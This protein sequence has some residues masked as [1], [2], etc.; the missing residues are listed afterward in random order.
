MAILLDR[1]EDVS[2]HRGGGTLAKC[3][4]ASC[5]NRA[6]AGFQQSDIN[7]SVIRWCKIHEADLCSK[8][9][10]RGRRLTQ[11]QLDKT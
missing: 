8:A 2:Q 4:V 7:K 1:I 11:E 10:G 3:D 6:I 5:D 9:Y